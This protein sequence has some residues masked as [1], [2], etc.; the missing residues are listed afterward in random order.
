M[1]KYG[2]AEQYDDNEGA[3]EALPIA[4]P[5]P[6]R[7]SPP[8]KGL[9]AWLL[10]LA[11]LQA[12]RPLIPL[13][14]CATLTI[15]GLLLASTLKLR[16]SL[17][18]LLPESQ[19]SVL[20]LQRVASRTDGVSN[21][22]VVLE[23]ED[24]QRLRD[25]GDALVP[26][27][28]AIG[29]PWV[30]SA[31]NSVDEAR[32]FLS[33]R[34]GLFAPIEELE[35]FRDEL[36][37]RW[38]WEVSKALGMDLL[39]D[40][41]YEEDDA[42]DNPALAAEARIRELAGDKAELLERYPDGYYQSQDGKALVVAVR[43]SI[44]AGELEGSQEALR[45]V[46]EV[47]QTTKQEAGF[48]D[49]RVDYTGDLVTSMEEYQAVRADLMQVGLLGVG[50]VLSAVLLYY[51]RFRTLIALALTV[52]AGC[53]WTFGLTK[54]TIGHLNVATG[55]LVSIVAGNGINFG[56]IYMARYLEARRANLP[57]PEAI[58]TAHRETWLP[59]LT[60]ALAAAAAYG[61]LVVTDFRGFKH[62]ALI[63]GAGMILCWLASFTLL[64]AIL[65]L[66]EK[67]R[68]FSSENQERKGIFN[69]L[70]H[71]GTRYDA[72]FVFLIERLP[73]MV[74]IVCAALTLG[75]A[76]LVV[77]YIVSD[78]IEYDMK[79]IR[80]DVKSRAERMR[81]SSLAGGLVGQTTTDGMAILVDRIDQVAPLVETLEARRDGA[82]PGEKPFEAVHTIYDFI[83][84]DQEEKLEVLEDVRAL[85]LRARSRGAI[86]DS[87]WAK[88]APMLPPEGLS[89]FD[90][91]D[92]PHSLARPFTERDGTRGRIV[93]ISPTSEE[94]IDDAKYLIRW[95]DAFRETSLPN[96]E[97]ILGS[98][99]AVIYADMLRTVVN[100][101]P[102]AIFFS[103]GATTLV[104]LLA[105]RKRTRALIVIGGLL[106][107]VAW[108]A[109]LFAL[110]GVKLNFLNFIALPMTFG[111][112]VDYAVNLVERYGE[113]RG[114]GQSILDVLKTTGGAVV[115][116]SVTTIL[117]YIALLGSL[118]QAVRS[119]GLAAVLGEICCLLA[120]VLFIPAA[121]R[122]RE[123]KQKPALVAVEAEG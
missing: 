38:D 59:T 91:E 107:G 80:N 6:E 69:R 48:G 64:P 111:I 26:E 53:A 37:E 90:I 13:L 88:I 123:R 55:F 19:A 67:V 47:V 117:G 36:Q 82:P 30:G 104:V 119:L 12:R 78:P 17:D 60:A 2:Q 8:D 11:S 101:A 71:R 76:A 114:R 27:L 109:G 3:D 23:G 74:A 43:T 68:P 50:L 96:G 83:P 51:L 110:F 98:G 15:I 100:D 29:P 24:S 81:L 49:I 41:E 1:A 39:D 28:E 14:V 121:A 46:S 65:V 56:I 34:A 18:Q 106:V 103:L 73:R 25:L 79:R 62:F 7:P 70:R 93:Y 4:R 95:A 97:T 33:Q 66:I 21:L 86:A 42:D 45:R 9:L 89:P 115:L 94:S 85:L 31:S 58:T 63:G 120:A 118:N 10:R 105:F 5:A 84:A 61:S 87:D 20:E 35:D 52:I 99:R 22:F 92:L 102:K 122:L 40:G 75:G 54:L 44:P 113:G 32:E 77:D 57:V 108:L 72:P 116:C 16:T 112:G